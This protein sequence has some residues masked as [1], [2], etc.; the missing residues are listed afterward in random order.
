MLIE[1]DHGVVGAFVTSAR[2]HPRNRAESWFRGSRAVL[3]PTQHY[4]DGLVDR[5]TRLGLLLRSDTKERGREALDVELGTGSDTNSS[6][7]GV[8]RLVAGRYLP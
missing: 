6:K 3:V 1:A 7:F 5:A 4:S 8:C 2:I